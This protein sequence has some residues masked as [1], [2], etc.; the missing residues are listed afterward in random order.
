MGVATAT[1]PHVVSQDKVIDFAKSLFGEG[2]HFSHLL[3]VY[4]NASVETR[5]FSPPLD[6]FLESHPF[7][8]VNDLYIKTAIELSEKVTTE[9]A[10]KSGI[11]T[12]DFDVVFFVSTTGLSTPSIDARLFNRIPMNPH[13]KRIPIWG[14]GCAGGASGMARA[15]DYLKAYPKHRAL[16]ITVEL[17]SLAFQRN[18]L[19]TTNVISTAIFGDGAAACVVFGDE[20]PIPPEIK[21]DRAIP[22]TISSFSTIYPN[23]LEVMSWRVTTEGFIVQLS[24]DIPSIVTSKVKGNI[25]EFLSG[26]E[27]TQEQIAHFIFHPGGM[28]VLTA[29]AEGLGLS[30]ERLQNSQN[31]LRNFGNMSSVTIFFVLKLFL[32]QT[33]NKSGEYGL[34][35][36]L[37]PGFS[38]ELVLLQWN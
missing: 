37:G 32:E 18:D 20:V 23:T 14:L 33:K 38:S 9:V 17:C 10:K 12:E 28:K 11:R 25:S 31:T 3:P 15:H 16:I 34:M 27:L 1:P 5:Y 26:N 8:E 4:E 6:W 13:I 19:S 7:T 30:M 2:K 21:S 36:A 35:G 24:R 22:S 29:Y